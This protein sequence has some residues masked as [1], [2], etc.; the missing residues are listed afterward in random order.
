MPTGVAA[1]RELGVDLGGRGRDFSGIRYRRRLRRTGFPTGAAAGCA[2]RLHRAGR[3]AA[4]W[5]RVAG[6]RAE[7]LTD[8]GIRPS[9]ALAA[10]FV[11]APTTCA[12][13]CAAG[14]R[15]TA[16]PTAEAVG[17]RQ[18]L[19]TG[20]WPRAGASRSFGRRRGVRRCS[21]GRCGVASGKARRGPDGPGDAPGGARGAFAG[22][23]RRSRSRRQAVPRP[24]AAVAS[25]RVALVGDAAGHLDALTGEG[26]VRLPRSARA[27]RASPWAS[28][29]LPA[30]VGAYLR[31][32][33][34]DAPGAVLA[35]CGR[36]RARRPRRRARALPALLG[37][38][39]RWPRCDALRARRWS[40]YRAAGR[41]G[42]RPRPARSPLRVPP[43]H[44]TAA[45]ADCHPGVLPA[46]APA[47]RLPELDEPASHRR[48]TRRPA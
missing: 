44:E 10:R 14:H 18:H 20:G 27:G 1:L 22:A 43:P 47:S 46:G 8:L 26:L 12:R 32:R 48:R 15:R 13:A 6:E 16:R 23:E 5:G 2:D 30:R 35:R 37:G 38:S 19:V 29:R 7:A 28:R 3:R 40:S 17:V 25:G 39:A 24:R 36:R 11:V 9:A 4:W 42:R 21:R 45:A 34:F 41:S 33:G 31:A